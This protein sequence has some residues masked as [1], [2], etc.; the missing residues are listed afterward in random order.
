MLL[1]GLNA[2]AFLCMYLYFKR[3]IDKRI[4]SERL[5]ER[6]RN[7]AEPLVEE[8][9][10]DLNR[11]TDRNITLI[12]SKLEELR[13]ILD[14][15]NKR[16]LLMKK[17]VEKEETADRICATL[18]QSS[19]QPLAGTLT[20]PSSPADA[21]EEARSVSEIFDL[22]RKGI[23]PDII[24]NTLDIPVGEVQLMIALQGHKGKS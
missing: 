12:E 7:K 10:Q 24:A 21:R 9:I 18:K 14:T 3:R 17:E 5:L 19:P 2:L 11:T 23:S 13:K 15:A 20:P 6:L 4:E 8:L 22:Y 16:I 1:L